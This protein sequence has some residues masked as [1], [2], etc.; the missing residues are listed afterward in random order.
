MFAD[1]AYC[2]ETRISLQRQLDTISGFC[3]LTKKTVNLNKIDIVAFR[4]GGP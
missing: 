1:I 3:R 4:N 2:A